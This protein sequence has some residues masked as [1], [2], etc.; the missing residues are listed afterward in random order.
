MTIKGCSKLTV[1]EYL[2]DL[3]LFC[4]FLKQYKSKK[5]TLGGEDFDK[6]DVS[7][8]DIDFFANVTKED[9]FSFLFFISEYRENSNPSR[10]RKLSAVKGFFK[11]LHIQVNRINANPAE[12]IDS[13][14]LKQSLPKFLSLEESLT[15]LQ[16]VEEDDQNPNR[17][18]DYCII[19]LFLNCGMRLSELVGINITDISKD[20]TSIKILGKRNKERY[21]YLNE[22]CQKALSEYLEERSYIVAD[23]E[24]PKL[25]W[26]RALFISKRRSKRICNSTVQKMVT[27]YFEKAGFAEKKYS[28]H[29]LRHTAATLMYQYGNVET[30]VLQQILGHEQL[31]TTQIYTHVANAQLIDAMSKS[32]LSKVNTDK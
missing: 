21:A 13:P 17:V 19:T 15:L 12:N 7:D 28:T 11:Y 24:N 23:S 30:R 14:S 5:G 16:T 8:L 9:I 25:Q 32:P 2:F 3:R 27:A 4:R 26:E 1:K 20:M 18:R 31:N 29:K 22:S 6:T 10:A